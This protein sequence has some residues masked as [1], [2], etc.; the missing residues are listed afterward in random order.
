M[1]SVPLCL[2]SAFELLPVT[3]KV[4]NGD[5]KVL[6][7]NHKDKVFPDTLKWYHTHFILTKIEIFSSFIPLLVLD[8]EGA[9]RYF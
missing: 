6:V 7:K 8:F 1:K 4:S 5:V 9:K 3:Y 2:L